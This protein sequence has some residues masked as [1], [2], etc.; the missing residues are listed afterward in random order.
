MFLLN[1]YYTAKPGKREDFL[2]ALYD[3]NIPQLCRGE[4]GNSQYD[5]FLS[6]ESPD[7]VL[8]VEKWDDAKS[9]SKHCEMQH[10]KAIESIKTQ[11][12]DNV[13]IEKYQA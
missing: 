5:Y 7:L 2:K 4:E 3:A 12:L 11:Y 10:M 8:L 6:N 9:Q 1:V 13:A